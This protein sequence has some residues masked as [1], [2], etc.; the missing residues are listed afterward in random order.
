[1]SPPPLLTRNFALLVTG[2]FL[3]ALGFGSLLLLPVYL[4]WLGASRAEIGT[5]MALAAVGGLATRPFVGWAL[6]TG[7]RKPTLLAGTAVLA[8]AMVGLL[9]VHDLG[10]LIYVDRLLFGVGGGTL[11]AGYFTWASDVIPPARRTEGIAL[12]G[13][14][15]LAPMALNAVIGKLGL[16]PDELPLLF[17]CVG[18]LIACSTLALLALPEPDRAPP[19]VGPPLARARDLARALAQRPLWPV[20][21]A[22]ALFACLV[23]LFFTFATVTATARAIPDPASVWAA[24]AAGAIGLRLF[25]ARGLDR[26]GPSNLVAPA[27]ALYLA[28]LVLLAGATTQRA[29]WAAGLLAGLGHG[30][31]FP[32]VVSLVVG[33]TPERWRG[34]AMSAFTATWQATELVMPPL[35]GLLA[36]RQDDAVMYAGAVGATLLGLVAWVALEQRAAPRPAPAPGPA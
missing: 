8:T 16:P 10:P 24:Y 33:R 25:G 5:L 36:D 9:A 1:M 35:F 31:C 29:L 4:A 20:W 12:F 13:V 34:S 28:A 3:Q 26:V 21:W 11:F 6:D 15:G 2:H 27:L 22:T 14:S 17:A 19:E 7:G 23:G 32:V 30:T 18:G